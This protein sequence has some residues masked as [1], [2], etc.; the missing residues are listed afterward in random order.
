[1]TFISDNFSLSPKQPLFAAV[2]ANTMLSIVP[3]ISGAGPSPEKTLFTPILDAELVLRGRITSMPSRPDTPTGCPTPASITRAMMDMCGIIP[4]FINAGLVHRPTVPCL[5]V[6]GEPGQDPR[7]TDAVPRTADL[8]EEG[9][10]LGALL[11]GV[12]DM[13]V[14]GECVPGGTTTALCVL[15][16]LGYPARVSSS[17]ADN[18]VGMKE[19]VW[20]A[21]FRRIADR[22][23]LCPLDAVRFCGDPMIPL[24]AG[25]GMG[26]RNR[27]SRLVLAGGTQMLAVAA[28]MKSLSIPLPMIAT[29]VYVRDDLSANFSEVADRI[30]V[31]V[32]YVDPGF[33]DLGHAG[34]ARYCIGEVKEGMGAGGAMFLAS[35][36]GHSPHDIRK[37]ILGTVS[38]Y[39]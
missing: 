23:P 18:P 15:R 25:I 9:R 8:F 20:E 38:V 30:G 21:V 6:Y 24:C 14:I 26:Y 19:A 28:L 12:C 10:I 11:S 13:L 7:S 33:G 36:M 34:L 16:A 39:Q 1:M 37:K 17:Y 35:I 3:G 29:T 5:D 32:A 31:P 2:L 27:E 22:M 4:L